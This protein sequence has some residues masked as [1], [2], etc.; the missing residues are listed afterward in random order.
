MLWKL[1]LGCSCY[2]KGKKTLV[3]KSSDLVK[4]LQ[5]SLTHSVLIIYRGAEN[6]YLGNVSR[7][8]DGWGMCFILPAV[9]WTAVTS[10][11]FWVL[12]TCSF[13]F[14]FSFPVVQEAVSNTNL[15][16]RSHYLGKERASEKVSTFP[17]LVILRAPPVRCAFTVT[18]TLYG[19][20]EGHMQLA[21]LW[22]WEQM[23]EVSM[24]LRTTNSSKKPFIQTDLL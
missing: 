15:S 3:K 13:W 11:I 17:V 19:T 12:M 8:G 6:S 20:T 10:L 23:W 5:A 16:S 7:E 9:Q 18:W 24:M 22:T 14:E 2:F 21:E 4:C 1:T